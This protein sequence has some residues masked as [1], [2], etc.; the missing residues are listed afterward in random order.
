MK[1]ESLHSFAGEEKASHRQ[2]LCIV[3]RGA[4]QGI[5]FRPF[6]Y[7][8]AKELNLAGWITNSLDGVEIEVEGNTG[9]LTQFMN[10]IDSEKPE[11]ALIQ[12]KNISYC[13]PIGYTEFIIKQSRLSGERRALVQP[14]IATCPDCLEEIFDP[15]DRRYRYPFT[16]C[17]N[18]GPRFSIIEKLP[19][20]R[21]NTTMKMFPMCDRCLEEYK[22]PGNRRFHAQ[23]TACPDCGPQLELWNLKGQMISTK[24][25][26]LLDACDA[27]T[28]GL[29][30]ALKGLGGFQ[31]LVDARNEDAVER[32]RRLKGRYEKPFA[33]MYPHLDAIKKHC[34]VTESEE[35]ILIS[36][37]SPIIILKRRDQIVSHISP[38]VAPDN[39]PYFGIMLPYT[40]LHHLLMAELEYP[41]VATSGNLS[42]ESICINE[43]E[44]LERLKNVADLFL[45]H[46]RPIAR[47]V[48]DSVVRIMSGQEFVIRNAR[49][50][51]PKSIQMTQPLSSTL[52]AVG[53]Q[54]KNSIALLNGENILLSQHIGDL[55]TGHAYGAFI[56]SINSLGHIYD[57]NPQET[58]T[59]LHPDYLSSIYASQLKLSS[60]KVQ[61]HRAHILSCLVD[62]QLEPPVLGVS[63]DGTGLG[64]DGT[65]WGSEFLKVFRKNY[66]RVAHLRYFKLPG[67]DQAI[68]E[69][70]RSALGV[71]YEIFGD[72]LFG[73]QNL[74]TL[75]SFNSHEMATIGKMLKNNINSPVT[76]SMGR[77]FDAVSSIVGLANKSGYE[78]QAAMKL[79]FAAEKAVT[80]DS[81]SFD[82]QFDYMPY[83]INWEPAIRS[84]LND[85]QNSIPVS[86]IATKFHNGLAEL[87][88]NIAARVN[89]QNV[90]LTGGCFQ[91]KCL[92]EK[93][94][95]ALRGIGF[96][97]LWHKQIPT[98]D[99]GLSAG[100]IMGRLMAG[101]GA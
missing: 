13:P 60:M 68:K 31:L 32:L 33:M 89:D 5:G 12:G 38:A 45:V 69:P 6:I 21:E 65:I 61:H 79:E 39:N 59:D 62:N 22:D 41:I 84:I 20:D 88:A 98:N 30:V 1:D 81:Y 17:T 44:A 82:V 49:G 37:K 100:Q 8:L 66:V 10:R 77:L 27:L 47:Q 23:P 15:D 4:V 52:L 71:L 26:S 40:P 99:G 51:A 90:V 75:D 97:P 9:K 83:I 53:A 86:T 46:N 2:R 18:C 25:Q 36:Q 76:S 72:K 11:L 19:Y 42:G 14:D 24:N 43:Y 78:G 93:T 3:I 91:N 56:K 96:N 64:D 50:Y 55:D 7:R 34:H 87:T 70:R 74:V 57:F 54:L 85:L 80:D 48:D 28:N 58:V 101:E 92:L 73:M 94:V 63:W 95:N 29:I 67:G 16:N 35:S